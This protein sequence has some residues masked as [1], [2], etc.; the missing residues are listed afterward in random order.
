MTDLDQAG[1]AAAKVIGMQGRG[2]DS[3]VCGDKGG[4][5]FHRSDPR[6]KLE[7]VSCEL[8]SCHQIPSGFNCCLYPWNPHKVA[9]L[10]AAA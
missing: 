8:H 3:A 1:G 4:D 9:P 6:S 7:P 5:V 10:C 2:A